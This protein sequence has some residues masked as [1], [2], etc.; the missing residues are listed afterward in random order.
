MRARGLRYEL[1]HHEDGPGLPPPQADRGKHIEM[2]IARL[3]RSAGRRYTD[4]RQFFG[5]YV[6]AIRDQCVREYRADLQSDP[7]A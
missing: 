6:A 4:R 2:G 5:T 3:A 1:E 7:P